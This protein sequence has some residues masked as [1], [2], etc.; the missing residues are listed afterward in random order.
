MV[1][2]RFKY[3]SLV[4]VG[5]AFVGVCLLSMTTKPKE[6]RD[7][8]VET[9]L[10][11]LDSFKLELDAAPTIPNN[12]EHHSEMK[13]R[14]VIIMSHGRSGSSLMGD[15]F[16]HHP[17]VFYM[18]EPLQTPE[19]VEKK[20]AKDGVL[21]VSYDELVQL[22]L[23]GVF[24]CKFDHPEMLSD[25]ERYYRKPGHPRVSHAIASPPLC[26]YTLTDPR[27]EP[28][29]CY[30]MT[31]ESLGSVCK[32]NYNLTVIKV[33]ISRVPENSINTILSTC[34]LLGDVDCN[35]V[36]LVR[37]PRAVIPSSRQIGFI[38][39]YKDDSSKNSVRAYSYQQCKQLEDN[40]EFIRK[41]PY[42]LRKRIRLQRY[43]DLARDPLKELSG[44]YEF[45]GLPVLQSVRTWL[46]ET[47]HLSRRNCTEMDGV[48][49][50]CTKDDAWAAVNRWRWKVN[51][52]DIDIIEHYCG[53]VM[54]LLGY[55]AVQRSHELLGDVK[56]ALFSDEFDAKHWLLSQTN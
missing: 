13:R 47:T 54:Q 31:S 56:T 24:R 8:R 20:A 36:F 32:N 28:A 12:L 44:L 11:N 18:Y 48:A 15:I 34:D 4:L 50:T 26:P 38:K 9:A 35:V 53:H 55:K 39:G 33:L 2:R 23:E 6:N 19:R 29:L 43:E 42:S 3:R 25:I 14:N 16:N 10:L 51:P 30:P 5:S 41:L 37:D 1:F 45:A 22:F 46:N 21:N 52:Y 7:L 27:W 40:L 49:V 17:S